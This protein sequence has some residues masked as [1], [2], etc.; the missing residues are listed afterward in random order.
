[1]P[2][3]QRLEPSTE[4]K[5]CYKSDMELIV[6]FLEDMS[7]RTFIVILQPVLMAC[8]ERGRGRERGFIQ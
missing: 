7:N 6:K 1:M 5:L 2:C 4:K 8:I 3:V